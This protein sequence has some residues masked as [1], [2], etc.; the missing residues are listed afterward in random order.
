[1]AAK[2]GLGKYFL[3]VFLCARI[4]GS[5]DSNECFED[6]C[7]SPPLQFEDIVPK[8]YD[9]LVPPTS[10]GEPTVVQIKISILNI[11]YVDEAKQ[12]FGV[13][14][15]FHQVWNDP[16]LKIPSSHNTSR[17]VLDSKWRPKLWTPDTYF[18]KL[19]EGKVNDII[20]P[21]SYMVLDSDGTLFFA[22][23]I[24][25]KLDCGMNL[26]AYPHDV[27]ECE[28]LIMSLQHTTKDVILLWKEFQITSSILLA[29]YS[30][31]G[32]ESVNGTKDYADIGKFSYISG[33]I[34]LTRRLGYF[35]IN[36]YIPCV[37]IICMSFITFWIPAE[38]Y[39]ARVTLS[40]TSLLTIVTQQYNSHMPEV[41]YVVALNIWMLSCIGF[42][43]FSL[44]EYAFVIAVM[45]DRGTSLW[46][47]RK[48][49]T[50]FQPSKSA[51]DHEAAKSSR[52]GT[53]HSK[54]SHKTIDK[55]SRV[56]FPFFFFIFCVSYFVYYCR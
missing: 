22:S 48:L 30:V 31:S 45:N 14:I 24:S 12:A 16:R 34:H 18:K 39:P 53:E 5:A 44:L 2:W 36:K 46:P 13:D 37:L 51:N 52:N 41:S 55:L 43:F 9:K 49:K 28:V 25:L 47:F 56:I 8:N 3:L 23:R 6:V 27:Q 35:L 7:S 40:V 38:A 19:V 32:T 50:I 1:M 26:A 10:N 54:M 17:L 29:Q 21:Y 20:I 11:N 4:C 42:V 15:F 33:K